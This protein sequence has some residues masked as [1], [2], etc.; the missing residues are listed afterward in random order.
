MRVTRREAA[1]ILGFSKVTLARWSTAKKGPPF[2]MIGNRA[3]YRIADIEI[4][5]R[6]GEPKK[7]A[8]RRRR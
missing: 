4:Y 8:P 5:Q 1:M 6:Y 2:I 7:R 3:M